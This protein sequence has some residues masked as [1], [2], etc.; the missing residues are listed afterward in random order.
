MIR[1]INATSMPSKHKPLKNQ[2]SKYSKYLSLLGIISSSSCP[3]LF[4]IEESKEK[5]R[6]LDVGCGQDRSIPYCPKFWTVYP[7]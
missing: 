5:S 2:D 1:I 4:M 7:L 3:A 6:Y